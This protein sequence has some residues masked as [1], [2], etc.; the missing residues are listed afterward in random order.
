VETF[1]LAALEAMACGTPVVAN[2]HSALPSVLGEAGGVSASTPRSFADAVERLLLVPDR[3][4]AARLRAEQ[5]PW[6]ATVEGFL[7][8]HALPVGPV[9]TAV[10]V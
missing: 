3:R 7:R 6:G 9:R 5:Y 4:R 2:H 1:G 8:A 10:Q